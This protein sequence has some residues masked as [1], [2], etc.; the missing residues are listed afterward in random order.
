MPDRWCRSTKPLSGVSWSENDAKLQS[1]SATSM[2]ECFQTS[3]AMTTTLTHHGQ[4]NPLNPPVS[5]TESLTRQQLADL[6]D[7]QKQELYH[8]AYLIQQARLAC[9]GCG[10]DD[11]AI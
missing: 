9:P 7:S 4:S 2:P 8:R 10:D 5:L 1:V 11:L 6:C 3:T